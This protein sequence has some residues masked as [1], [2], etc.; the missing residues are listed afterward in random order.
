M[1]GGMD[2]CV[3]LAGARADAAPAPVAVLHADYGQRT[4]ARER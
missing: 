4:E 3:T 1:S 2:S